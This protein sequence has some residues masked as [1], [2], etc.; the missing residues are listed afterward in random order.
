MSMEHID[1]T[2]HYILWFT[3]LLWMSIKKVLDNVTNHLERN[4][5]G[6]IYGDK[7]AAGSGDILTVRKLRIECEILQFVDPEVSRNRCILP[8]NICT[9]IY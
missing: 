9:M 8:E 6:R 2:D 4:P 1:V 3:G 5:E 7:M